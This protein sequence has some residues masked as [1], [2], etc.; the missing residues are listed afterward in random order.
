MFSDAWRELRNSSAETTA[1]LSSLDGEVDRIRT[2]SI[3]METSDKTFKQ[4]LQAARRQLEESAA[5]AARPSRELEEYSTS[6]LPNVTAKGQSTATLQ[7]PLTPDVKTAEKQGWLFLKTLSGKPSKTLWVRRWFYVRNGIFGWLVQSGRSGGVEE[8]EQIGVLLCS[9]RPALQEERRFC[10]EVKTKDNTI[11]IQAE[12]QAELTAWLEVFEKAKKAALEDSDDEIRQTSGPSNRDAAF[13][14]TPPSVA[15]FAAKQ[16][17]GLGVYGSEDSGG[18]TTLPVLEREARAN[19]DINSRR[20]TT[21]ER[22]GESV[23][24]SASRIIQKLD[25]H[26]KSAAGSQLASSATGGPPSAGLGPSSGAKASLLSAGYNVSSL[27]TTPT[28]GSFT[29]TLPLSVSSVDFASAG[30]G[31]ANGSSQRAESSTPSTL[32]PLTLTNPPAPTNLSKAAAIYGGERGVE[33]RA[34]GS[35]GSIPCGIMANF[36][37]TISSPIINHLDLGNM[38]AGQDHLPQLRISDGE[39]CQHSELDGHGAGEQP[40]TPLVLT[41]GLLAQ[42]DSSSP[43]PQR[44]H[45]NTV[46]SA[47]GVAA[48]QRPVVASDNYPPNYPA[49]LRVQDAQFRI[50]FPNVP[51]YDKVVYVFRA[52]WNPNE[53]LDFP[54]RVYVTAKDLYF[55]SHHLGLV[56]TT[57]MSLGSI[58]GVTAATEKAYDHVFLNLKEGSSEAGFTRVTIKNFLEPIGL[59]RRRL[60]CLVHNFHYEQPL[61]LEAIVDQLTAMEKDIPTGSPSLASWE[62]VS[63]DTPGNGGLV[64]GNND[65]GRKERDLRTTIRVDQSLV[66]ANVAA[67]KD[68]AR[69]KLPSEP[70]LYSPEDLTRVSQAKEFPV[71]A[72]ALFHVMFGDKSTL[73]QIL[74]LG[75]RTQEGS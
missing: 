71:S 26:R 5:A 17:D 8:S 58:D 30:V 39:R 32:A 68:S 62:D 70:V 44:A 20:S 16:S 31:I 57:S 43:R 49:N 11:V 18:G 35:S 7:P 14:I 56:L 2:W 33:A 73:F 63:I 19:L 22:D 6:M 27:Q 61:Q 65:S 75:R 55:Y 28:T 48:L 74:Y 54:G 66:T 37:G 50:L 29:S 10:F 64:S 46:S 42:P 36:W 53:R 12:S 38:Q 24:D 23:R 60:N 21:S 45:R 41:R 47:D 4:Q 59:L 25:L 1:F 34:N 40:D 52:A 51:R 69:L 72:K 67:K 3:E 13:A 15:V 9:V